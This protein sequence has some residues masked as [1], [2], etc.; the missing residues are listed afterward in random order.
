VKTISIY[1]HV[2][3][4]WKSQKVSGNHSAILVSLS[5]WSGIPETVVFH[6]SVEVLTSVCRGSF[7]RSSLLPL[8]APALTYDIS[9]ISIMQASFSLVCSVHLDTPV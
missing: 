3:C 1:H 5:Q 7:I 8:L 2:P 9:V 6:L 4:H